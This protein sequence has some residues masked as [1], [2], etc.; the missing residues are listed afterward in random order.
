M[1]LDTFD[2]AI[3]ETNDNWDNIFT[4]AK[5]NQDL[6][7]QF[8]GGQVLPGWN[9]YTIVGTGTAEYPQAI[10]YYKGLER[11]QMNFTYNSFDFPATIT[12]Y[13][14]RDGGTTW[15][16]PLPHGDTTTVALATCTFTYN[17]TTEVLESAA[18]S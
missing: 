18:W 11:F 8:I 4:D 7:F 15:G 10:G 12:Y 1:A 16:D 5:A 17:A 9:L 13:Y 3:P 2:T 14:S 6:A